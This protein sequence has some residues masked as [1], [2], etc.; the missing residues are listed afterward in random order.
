[1]QKGI[2]LN[3]GHVASLGLLARKDGTRKG[4]L[5]KRSSDN[6]KWQTKWF[7]LLQNLLFYFESDSSSR[8]SGLYLLEGCVCDRAPSPKPALSAKEP[9]EKQ[10]Y[11]TVNFSHENQKALELRTE[12]AKDCDEWVAAIAHASYRTLATEHEALMQ[13]YLHLLQI[14]ETEKTVAK[15]LRQQIE[16]GEIEIERLKAE[17]ASLLKDNERIQS[18][19]T[20]APNDEDSDIKKIKKVQSFLRGWLCRRKW[21]TIIQDYI[22]SPHADSMRKRNQVVFSMLEA[23]AE[24]VQQLHILVNNFLRPLR[25]AASSKKPPITHDDVSSIFLNSETIMFL[26]QI[27]YQGLKARISS[28]PTLVLADLF[29]ILLPMLNIYQ[30]FVRNHQYSLQILA[31]CKQN[32]DFDKLL[33]HYEAKPDCE[34]R[35]LETFLTYPMFQIPRYILTLHE[36]LAHTPHEHVE[37]NSLDYAKSKLEELSRIMH[38]EVSE[39]ENIRKNLAIE[40]MIIEGCEILLDTSQTFVRQGSLIQVPMSEKGKITRGRLGSLSLKKE[41]ERQCFLFSK[42]LIICTRGSGGKLHLTKNGVI[43]LIDCTLLEEPESTEEEA[44][45]SSQD[46][47]HLDFKIG[48]EPKDSPPFTVILVASS[49]Q[50]KAAWTSDISQC[51]DNIRCNGLMMNAFEENSKVTVPQMIKSDAS[52]YCDDVDIRFSKTMNSCKVLQIRYASVERLLERLT[53]LRFLS[54]DFLNTFLHS[55]RVFTTAVVVLDK[56]ITIYKKPISAIPARSLELLFASGQ[57]NKLLYG[58]PPKSPRATRKFSSPPPLSITKTS[59]PSRRRKLSL[60]I[61][62][63]TGGKALDLA[64]LSCNSNGYTSMYSAM[65]P[66]SKATLDT[67]KLY[68]S[69]SFTN[70]IPDEGDTTPEKPEDPSVLSKQSSE[71]SVREESDTDQN[72]SDDGDTETSPTKSPTTP[73]SVK[74]KNSSEFPLFSYNNGVVMTSCRELDNNRSA[75]SAASAFAIATAG[76]NEGTPNKE[77]YRRMSLASAGFP[78]DQRNGDKEF[79]I[80]RAATNRVLNVLR[81]WVSKHSQ[82]FETNDELKCKVIGFLEEVMH[83]PELLTQERKAAANIIRTLTQEDPGDNQ[84]TLEEITQMAEG[85]KAEPFENHSALEIAE[86]LT[87]LDHLVFKKIPYE[88]FFGQGWMKL[89]KNER[90]PYIM[91]TTKHFNDI[92]NLIASEII[93]NEDINARVSAIE[94]WV[95]VADICRCLHNYNAVLEITSSMNRSAI[96]RLKKTWLKVSKQTKALIDKLQKLVSSEGRFKNLREALKNCDPPCVP[97]LGMYLTDLAFIE[98]GTPNY[99]EDGLVNFSKMRMISHIIREIRQFQQTAYKIEHQAKVTQYLLDQ[100]F[101]MDEESLY[102]SSLRIEPKLPT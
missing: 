21:K 43:S 81:H 96:F 69:S 26:H 48:V 14:V 57:N 92:S 65:S 89:E 8:P 80:R 27:F 72:Q 18:T 70:K 13:K 50:E 84:I 62:I 68:V 46:I 85:V 5:S 78:P 11:F 83:D 49:R 22:R 56:L 41:G 55:Y 24:Y 54:I 12:D 73:K 61:P 36:L 4:Y 71:V 53:D 59:S 42:H 30:E 25:M 97:Y 39:T 77:K 58:D 28:W 29:D 98:E 6:T 76:A 9:L 23:E 86:Q 60:N 66:F 32:R 10:H 3:D 35:T 15:Q 16:D 20:V 1:M 101:V 45:G 63:I 94:K 19:Q 37:R 7:A 79:V 31:H 17:I 93:R 100:S 99:T 82:D 34:E 87:L 95:A 88:E 51:V 74:S 33:K 91:K 102:E 44:K 64:A 2:R 67:S 47:D 90:T 75:L 38:D 40:R 52:L